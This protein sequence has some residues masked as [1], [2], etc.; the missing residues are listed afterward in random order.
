MIKLL[1]SKKSLIKVLYDSIL[2][3]TDRL[4]KYKYFLPY[5]ETSSA[6][7]LIYIFLK[8]I[9]VNY[10]LL[11]KII[12][13]RDKLLTFKFWKSL[14][15]QLEI[16]HKLSILYHSQTNNHI[17]WLNQTMKQYLW[18]YINYQQ[19]NWVKLLLI[20]QFAYNS[21]VTKSTEVLSF[22][23]NYSFNPAIDEAWE[24]VVIAQKV[25]VQVNW[26]KNLH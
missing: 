17:E 4:M 16:H 5:K 1:K 12:S 9:A 20:A 10:E 11:E 25:K 6:E 3:I 18:C 13:D 8:S 14:M 15:N 23:I 2:I 19:I 22:Y 21:A 7:K 26:L 24:L